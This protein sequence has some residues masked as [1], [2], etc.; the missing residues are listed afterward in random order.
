[1]RQMLGGAIAKDLSYF[2]RRVPLDEQ[3]DEK[4]ELILRNHLGA[5]LSGEMSMDGQFN[6]THMMEQRNTSMEICE[7]WQREYDA[8]RK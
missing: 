8:R 3:L 5:L 6:F 2:S 1:M 4:Q 7:Q